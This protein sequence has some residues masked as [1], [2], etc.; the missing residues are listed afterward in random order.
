ME[1]ENAKDIS[2]KVKNI[3]E[4]LHLTHVD[5]S[6]ITCFRSFGSSSRARARIWSFPKVWQLA[7]H[8]KPC[9]IIEVLSE[10]FD[11][12]SHEDQIRVLIHELMH[13]PKN[14]SGSLLPHRGR[15][16]PIDHHRVEKLFQ[17]LKN[18]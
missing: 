12:L 4:K 15:G 18:I 13:I 7:L 3:I 17:L 14:F 2:I 10:H 9:Y 11:R 6:R 16:K 5:N 8:I 1:W